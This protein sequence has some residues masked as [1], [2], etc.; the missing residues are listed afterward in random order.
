MV[1]GA[2]LG[3]QVMEVVEVISLL[4]QSLSPVVSGREAPRCIVKLSVPTLKDRGTLLAAAYEELNP[5]TQ[6]DMFLQ[7]RPDDTRPG[8]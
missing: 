1:E 8:S 6:T 7:L 4:V 2:E 3:K 5:R